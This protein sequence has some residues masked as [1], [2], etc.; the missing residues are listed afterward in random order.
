M[1]LVLLAKNYEGYQNLI[2]L[3]SLASTENFKKTPYLTMDNLK[4]Y[5]KNLI[6][7]SSSE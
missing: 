6:A 1:G 4:Q 5:G 7:L 2:K 3:I